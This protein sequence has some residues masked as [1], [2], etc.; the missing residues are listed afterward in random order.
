MNIYTQMANEMYQPG[1]TGE[2]L[3]MLMDQYAS[4]QAGQG[5]P[6]S[7]PFNMP[8]QQYPLQ[9]DED[10]GG[11]PPVFKMM[12]QSMQK[13]IRTGMQAPAMGSA[14]SPGMATSPTYF[15]ANSE[16][17]GTE[18]WMLENYPS[19]FTG[20]IYDDGG[21]GP[22]SAFNLAMSI[23]MMGQNDWTNPYSGIVEGIGNYVPILGTVLGGMLEGLISPNVY[24]K[25]Q[26]QVENE[27][28]GKVLQD[29]ARATI[30]GL[31]TEASTNPEYQTMIANA[32][33]ETG[34]IYGFALPPGYTP[35]GGEP[36]TLEGGGEG[37]AANN[38]PT[39]Y[40]PPALWGYASGIPVYPEELRAGIDLFNLLGYGNVYQELG[41]A[42]GQPYKFTGSPISIEGGGEGG[43]TSSTGY[44][45]M[46]PAEM[47]LSPEALMIMAQ[48]S[49]ISPQW[50]QTY[51]VLGNIR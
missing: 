44:Q 16:L 5:Q 24:P 3:Q 40:T 31:S 18:P 21:R 4:E 1:V 6:V 46:S 48:L 25:E 41:I 14:L 20:S 29:W 35:T 49:Q 39:P 43:L 34:N 38:Y 30:G 9:P 28:R 45:E 50:A 27:A 15:N 51:G 11:I 13:A 10:S 8:M 22:G 33:R 17:Y 36:V 37:I 2:Y 7:Q 32:P 19:D 26:F 42:A 23:A 47:T 12:A